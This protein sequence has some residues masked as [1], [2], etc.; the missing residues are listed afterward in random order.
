MHIESHADSGQ[1]MFLPFI[2]TQA[3]VMY[4]VVDST[5]TSPKKVSS[6]LGIT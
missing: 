6:K 4:N 2:P 5:D 3:S 1:V